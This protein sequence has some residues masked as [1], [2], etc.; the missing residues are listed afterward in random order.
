MSLVT[1]NLSAMYTLW[2]G[3]GVP[4]PAT[5]QTWNVCSSGENEEDTGD[6]STYHHF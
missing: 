3:W 1:W 4:G 6:E 5:Q 2:P